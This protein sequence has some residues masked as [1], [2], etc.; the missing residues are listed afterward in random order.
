MKNP[1]AIQAAC[2]RFKDGELVAGTCH[3]TCI[4][5]V[6]EELNWYDSLDDA[7]A[8][9]VMEGFVTFGGEVLTREQAYVRAV[10]TGM[11]KEAY[12]EDARGTYLPNS[13]RDTKPWL[14]SYSFEA[15]GGQLG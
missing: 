5:R 6:V 13:K 3:A 2:V 11:D 14:E 15:A 9:I 8:A 4:T 7:W 1:R 12:D 10:E